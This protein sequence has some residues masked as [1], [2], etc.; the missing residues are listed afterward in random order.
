MALIFSGIEVSENEEIP[1]TLLT[2]FDLTSYVKRY[3]VY[4]STWTPVLNEKLCSEVEPDNLIDKYAVAVKREGW[5]FTIGKKWKI[6]KDDF[7]LPA[8]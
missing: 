4:K 3:H 6:C 1:I 5:P 8:S 7:L 2:C